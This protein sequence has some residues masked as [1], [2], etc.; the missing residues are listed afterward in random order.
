M[1]EFLRSEDIGELATALAV[2]QAVIP[3]IPRNREV[4]VQTRAGGKYT[5]KYATLDAILHAIKQ[6]LA[7]NGLS[8]MQPVA[9]REDGPVLQTV[10]THKSGQWVMSEMPLSLSGTNQECGSELTYKRR[11]SLSALLNISSQEDDDANLADG[12]E[13]QEAKGNG[14]KPTDKP[15]AGEGMASQKQINFAWNLAQALSWDKDRLKGE[16]RDR[17]GVESS[18]E[19]TKQNASDLIEFLQALKADLDS[20]TEDN[21]GEEEVPL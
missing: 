20:L 6:P 8:V 11:Y 5:F 3:E 4:A 14:Q 7:D 12:N 2:A 13:Y 10:L 9:H 19:L 21:G 18:K 16:L 15:Q 17:Y 1:S